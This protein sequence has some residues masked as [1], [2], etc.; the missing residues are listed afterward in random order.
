[1]TTDV[2]KIAKNVGYTEEQIQR[3][4]DYLFMDIHNLGD[5]R[6]SKFDPSYEIAQSWQRLVDGKSI[7]PHDM[8]LLL[9]EMMEQELMMQGY[10][11]GE[12]HILA[13]RKYDYRKGCIEYYGSIEE[14]KE[15]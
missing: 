3:I 5:G 13:S 8:T 6:I 7:Q 1:M 2:K 12:A 11:Q 15:K 10:S 4:K 14:D 9:H